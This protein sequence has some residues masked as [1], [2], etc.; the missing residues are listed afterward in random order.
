[1]HCLCRSLVAALFHFRTR[2][3]I[4]ACGLSLDRWNRAEIFGGACLKLLHAMLRAE[5]IALARMF[6]TAASL[7]VDFHAA[8]MIRSHA[9]DLFLSI[10]FIGQLHSWVNCV[11][12]NARI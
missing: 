8:Y 9:H 7:G 4:C 5:V 3:G 1:M 12:R 2:I 6:Q 10:A 11:H